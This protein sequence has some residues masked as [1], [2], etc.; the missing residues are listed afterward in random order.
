M[1]ENNQRHNRQSEDS[2]NTEALYAKMEQTLAA[3]RECAIPQDTHTPSC[4]PTQPDN[5][6]DFEI[7]DAVSVHRTALQPQVHGVSAP[8]P[9]PHGSCAAHQKPQ[10]TAHGKKHINRKES[11][12]V[13]EQKNSKQHVANAHN[14]A[15]ASVHNNEQQGKP[16]SRKTPPAK[17]ARKKKR[18]FLLLCILICTVLLLSGAAALLYRH[19]HSYTPPLTP[20]SATPDATPPADTDASGE[21][22][23]IPEREQQVYN[24]L[25]TGIDKASHSADVIMVVRFDAKDGT[26]DVVQ[27]P[28]DTYY[29]IAGYKTHKINA[30]FASYY[31][32]AQNNNDTNPYA[33]AND[34]FRNFLAQNLGVPI[35]RYVCVDTEGFCEIVDAFGGV[36]VDVPMDMDYDDP[37]QGLSIHLKKGTQHLTGAQAE[38]LV[39]F[40]SGFLN[41]DIGRISMQKI[42][43]SAMFRQVKENMTL[44]AL[45]KTATAAM[46]YVTTDMSAEDLVYFAGKAMNI[47]MDHIRFATMPGGGVQN[48][49]TGA[50]YYVLY[51]TGAEG[52]I[53]TH[54]EVYDGDLPANFF[55]PKGLFCNKDADYVMNVYYTPYTYTF[56]DEDTAQSID[57]NSIEI[58]HR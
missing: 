13:M 51:K 9:Q 21:Q 30:L 44:S 33:S 42:F 47:S 18:L 48:P 52:I 58:P 40:R 20:P 1:E 41:A 14:N 2:V 35:D 6:P 38:G 25:V 55:N 23:V 19:F 53:Q 43:L 31:N 11:K 12:S 45:V 36:T 27:I 8:K 46:K 39:R 49:E 29:N 3:A 10:A 26:T 15:G 32:A 16:S 17:S 24:I 50:W 37:R 4:T 34:D 22:I 56:S 28:R 5:T 54:L 57:D 7:L